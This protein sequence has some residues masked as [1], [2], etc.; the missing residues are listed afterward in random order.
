MWAR[1]ANVVLGVWLVTSTL[2]L[3]DVRAQGVNDIASGLLV[4]AFAI[5][6]AVSWRSA[7]LLNIV[8]A[9]WLLLSAGLFAHASAAAA[10]NQGVVGYLICAFAVVPR[11]G[12]GASRPPSVPVNW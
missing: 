3:R 6:S 5:T 4:I 9:G 12:A 8:I 1:V 2:F 7:R 10:W 11:E